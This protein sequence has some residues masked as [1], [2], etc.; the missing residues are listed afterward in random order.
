LLAEFLPLV[1]FER[2][3]S[4]GSRV[5][6]HPFRLMAFWSFVVGVLGIVALQC[7]GPVA[8]QGKLGVS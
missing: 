8:L 1:P 2:E 7:H 6:T 5:T 4:V 3:V